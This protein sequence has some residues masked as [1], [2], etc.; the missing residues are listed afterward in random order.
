MKKKTIKKITKQLT[1]TVSNKDLQK[2]ID[3]QNKIKTLYL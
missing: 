3:K 1:V 2:A